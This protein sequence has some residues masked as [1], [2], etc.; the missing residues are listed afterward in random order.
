MTPNEILKN[1]MAGKN[2]S[3]FSCSNLLD[4]TDK[5][6][7]KCWGKRNREFAT[8]EGIVII[9]RCSFDGI[10]LLGTRRV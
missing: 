1:D 5:Q 3:Q 8:E 7:S 9:W 10:L 6:P 4:I 2:R